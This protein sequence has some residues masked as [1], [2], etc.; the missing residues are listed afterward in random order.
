MCKGVVDDGYS[1]DIQGLQQQYDVSLT[2]FGER[3][4]AADWAN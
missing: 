4:A 3:V 1:D 2:R